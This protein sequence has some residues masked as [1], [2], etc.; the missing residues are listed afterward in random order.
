MNRQKSYFTQIA[1]FSALA[2]YLIAGCSSSLNE[3]PQ[4]VDQGGQLVENLVSKYT[5][6][7]M[8]NFQRQTF[9]LHQQASK[10]CSSEALKKNLEELQGQWAKA[11]TTYHK[12][13]VV[14]YAPESVLD[15]EETSP[16]RFIYRAL[17]PARAENFI[18][19]QIKAANAQQ[20]NY[21]MKRPLSHS[22]GL[23]ALEN[24]LFNI[25]EA[26]TSFTDNSGE[27][28]FLT[29]TTRKLS[30]RVAELTLQWEENELK[31]LKSS[32]GQAEVRDN[33][34]AFTSHVVAY[35]EKNLKSLRIAAPLGLRPDK[36]P[37]EE[38][39]AAEYLEHPYYPNRKI[40][41]VA[42]LEVISELF[43][44]S[45]DKAQQSSLKVNFT[46]YLKNKNPNLK[47]Q[48]SLFALNE[49]L[50][51][52]RLLPEGE[53]YFVAFY[54]N[55]ND[56]K[57]AQFILDSLTKFTNWLKSDFLMEMN[58]EIPQPVQGDND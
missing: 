27:C 58:T 38:V 5:D 11:M 30:E 32:V 24:L 47:S 34:A 36:H 21:E 50:E 13:K 8:V 54:G 45:D 1:V 31:R 15:E 43:A 48:S 16:L 14:M 57:E 53:D 6:Q 20:E 3:G 42:P 51:L 28:V 44:D 10:L 18:R 40:A 19:R 35:T 23:N 12:L 4:K 25:L 52:S 17:P 39:C 55:V 29:Y 37:C 26:D 9:E 56:H 33:L 2:Y 49:A 22:T 46:S 41:L 7:Y